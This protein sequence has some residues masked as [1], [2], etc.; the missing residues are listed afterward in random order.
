MTPSDLDPAAWGVFFAATLGA[1]ATLAGLLFVAVSINLD[2]VVLNK[3]LLARAGETLIGL[4]LSLVASAAELV[5]QP[6]VV[7]AVVLLVVCVTVGGLTLRVQLRH[8]PDRPSDP[9]WWFAVRIATV[10]LVAVPAAVGCI[11]V[12]AGGG[13]GLRWVAFGVIA[14]FALTIYS[15]WVLLVEIVRQGARRAGADAADGSGT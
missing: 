14:G 10:Q 6:A 9:W 2:R 13:G 7:S 4:V 8:G 12:L 1:A 11:G 3:R 5:P 15:A